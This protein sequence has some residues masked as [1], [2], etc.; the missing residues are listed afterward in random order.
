VQPLGALPNA[1]AFAVAGLPDGSIAASI[2]QT[3]P[4]GPTT[5]TTM[6]WDGSTWTALHPSG[7]AAPVALRNGDVL[8]VGT[9][10]LDATRGAALVRWA[11]GCPSASAAIASGCTAGAATL[12]SDAPWVGQ[13]LQLEARRSRRSP[14]GPHAAIRANRRAVAVRDLG[15]VRREA[16][17]TGRC[18]AHTSPRRHR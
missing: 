9:T 5:R 3:P 6:R 12:T 17:G 8:L 11:G 16:S 2:R 13:T 10:F 1:W 14:P 7:D 4:N 18:R 15:P